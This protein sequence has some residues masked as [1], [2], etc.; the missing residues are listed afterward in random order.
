MSDI[1]LENITKSFNGGRKVL[2]NLSL[3]VPI[4]KTTCIMGE[5]GSGKTT[6]L[7]IIAGLEKEFDGKISGLPKRISF[8]FQEDRLC[9]E[10][11]AISNLRLVAN[12]KVSK[13]TIIS[14]LTELGLDD[15]LK[16][17]VSEFSGGMKRR[18]AIARAIIFNADL[19]ILDEP[20]KGLDDKLKTSVM[21]YVKK[22]TVDK[23]VIC[24]THDEDE[25]KYLGAETVLLHKPQKN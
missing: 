16:K 9:E 8:V 19:L 13:E 1:I 25:A 17:P 11:S 4:G 5:S 20:F 2:D 6:L 23:T 21:D 7:R 14:H 12:K 15:S 18:V 22:H 3:T 10:F 24:V